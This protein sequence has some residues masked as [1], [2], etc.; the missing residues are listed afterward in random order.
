M[1]PE[2]TELFSLRNLVLFGGALLMSLIVSIARVAR[3]RGVQARAGLPRTTLAEGL[4]DT[5]YGSLAAIAWLLIQ[6]SLKPLPIKAALGLA[7]FFGSIGPTTWDLVS[8]LVR[9]QYMLTKKEE[10]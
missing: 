10:P 9:G 4:A 1:T 2:L 7:M 8:A 3:E 6:D 5:I